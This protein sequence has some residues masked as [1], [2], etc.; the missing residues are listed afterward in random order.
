M[1]LRQPRSTRTATL[2]PYTTLFRSPDAFGDARSF[3][4]QFAA[5]IIVIKPRAVRVGERDGD[6]GVLRL[7]SEP[8][9]RDRAAGARGAGEAVDAAVHLLPYLLGGAK[10]MRLAVGD[11]VEL[12]RPD[13]VVGF[14]GDAARGVD[15]MAGGRDGR[16]REGHEVG[17]RKG[18]G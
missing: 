10:D 2:L 4:F 7:Q 11:I 13:R 15:E 12:V 16:G 5:L 14:L 1:I 17:G 6:V 3:G 18:G 8:G 9:A